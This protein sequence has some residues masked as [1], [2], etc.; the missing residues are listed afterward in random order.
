MKI[1]GMEYVAWA[2]THLALLGL[3]LLSAA[4]IGQ[5]LLR[6]HRFDST[7]E[8][9]VFVTAIGLG[10]M[11]VIIFMLGLVGLMN[12]SVIIA[13]TI[14]SALFT[15]ITL[16]RSVKPI[17]AVNLIRRMK[18][19]P[20]RT[21]IALIFLLVGATSSVCLIIPTLYPP[22]AWDSTDEHLVV[23]REFLAAHRPVVLMGIVEPI[24]PSL[25]HV[26]F[27][28]GMA[29]R[30]DV[31]AQ[32]LEHS[33]L[34][35]T[36]LG[37]YSLGRRQKNSWFGVVLAA[38]WIGNPMV[39]WLGG[40]AYV[41]LCLVCFAFLGVY[42]L[43]VFWE[44][45]DRRWWYLAMAL[46][47]MAAGAKLPGLL[48]VAGGMLT[49]LTVF[50][51]SHW[52]AKRSASAGHAVNQIQHERI[53]LTTIVIGGCAALIAAAPWYG[54]IAVQTG[55]PFWPALTR[56]SR[57]V[58]GAP[59]LVEAINRLVTF[60]PE[61][62]TL[63]SFLS[64]SVN[65]LI[66][67]DGFSAP[68]HPPLNPL[69]IVWPLAWLVAI[70]NR[71]V[72]WWAI[73]A[74]AFTLYWFTSSQ[75]LR[76]WLPALPLCAVALLSSL[77][78]VMERTISIP[79]S[80]AVYALII[81]VSAYFGAQYLGNVFIN[82]E[83]PPVTAEARELYL[84]RYVAGYEAVDYINQHAKPDDVVTTIYVPWLSYYV[85]REVLDLHGFLQ[86]G[87]FP[88][89]AW[90][91]DEQWMRWIEAKNSNWI[92]VI[93]EGPA[94]N[95]DPRFEV[96]WPDYELIYS[97]RGSWIFLR[98]PVPPDLPRVIDGNDPLFAPG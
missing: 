43:R 81:L 52:D 62:R 77:R 8:R 67:P 2:L 37:L 42:A 32:M 5:A 30:D 21:L 48:F 92:L 58:W 51:K 66:K 38:F 20:L 60:A 68:I 50:A 31:M 26:L 97:H 18:G 23:A 44:T 73:W 96:F 83:P 4:G 95:K 85:K 35:L 6:R 56:F 40:I 34:A 54:F 24:L 87:R 7:V 16:A 39:I 89:F 53:K 71:E 78:W 3:M 15:I 63:K 91:A 1:E 76:Y 82:S 22:T 57:G 55:N 84:K 9:L 11:A 45:R 86:I 93:P 61:P 70:W 10:S 94:K 47:G 36:A 33:F 25:N 88:R 46:L 80:R 74:L 98:K 65:W 13:I 14:L 75:D 79:W 59:I 90:P 29:L 19:H 69:I 12:R 49:G 27:A 28:W 17:V 41:D 72:R 64:L